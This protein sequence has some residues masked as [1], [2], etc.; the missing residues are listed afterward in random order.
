M[1]SLKHVIIVCPSALPTGT[2]EPLRADGHG[3][4]LC[5][6]HISETT[7]RIF[8]IRSSTKLPID[9]SLCN[10]ITFANLPHRGLP[11][12]KKYGNNGAMWEVCFWNHCIKYGYTESA[13]CLRV[14][15]QDFSNTG[16]LSDLKTYML[17]HICW[18]DFNILA[19]AHIPCTL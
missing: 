11:M 6:M 12:G 4:S 3:T 17:L 13:Y 1:R 7:G 16:L 19:R 2:V 15:Y 9:L 8:S 5:G 18:F 10:G 14:H